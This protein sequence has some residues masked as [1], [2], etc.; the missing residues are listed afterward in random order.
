MTDPRTQP[1]APTYPPGMH[2]LLDQAAAAQERVKALAAERRAAMAE[3]DRLVCQAYMEG[4]AGRTAIARALHVSNSK[5]D[6]ILKP[7]T[8]TAAAS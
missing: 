4:E 5:I 8:H 3:R 2:L 1:P 6:D 7:C